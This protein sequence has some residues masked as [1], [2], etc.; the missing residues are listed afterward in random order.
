VNLITWA[1]YKV[2]D[3]Q[4]VDVNVNQMMWSK[5]CH[6]ETTMR[7]LSMEFITIIIRLKI[8]KKKMCHAKYY[9]EV[10]PPLLVLSKRIMKYIRFFWKMCCLSHQNV[11]SIVDHQINSND[12]DNIRVGFE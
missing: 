2:N 11:F 1:F 12:D 5:I 6:G 8:C 10:F 7:I 9:V 3:N 4:L